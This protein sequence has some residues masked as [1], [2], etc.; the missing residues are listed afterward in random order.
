MFREAQELEQQQNEYVGLEE[1]PEEEKQ[2][3][4]MLEPITTEELSSSSEDEPLPPVTLV[5]VAITGDPWAAWLKKRDAYVRP[6]KKRFVVLE[7]KGSLW[8]EELPPVVVPDYA[9]QEPKKKE[10]KKRASAS[11]DSSEPKEARPKRKSGKKRAGVQV[12]DQP[13]SSNIDSPTS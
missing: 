12:P 6:R 1:D 3:L 5:P 7:A 8:G 9:R 2:E 13:A 11:D 4:P 10:G